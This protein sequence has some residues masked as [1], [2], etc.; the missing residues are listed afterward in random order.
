MELP[1]ENGIYLKKISG[2]QMPPI[3]SEESERFIRLEGEP[4][5]KGRPFRVQCHIR[6]YT[7]TGEDLRRLQNLTQFP[8]SKA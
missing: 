2:F 6:N 1:H 5:L 8:N 3:D 4:I 7:E